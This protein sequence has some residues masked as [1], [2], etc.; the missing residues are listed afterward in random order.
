MKKLITLL[1]IV[2]AGLMF[3]GVRYTPEQDTQQCVQLGAARDEFSDLTD[4][5]VTRDPALTETEAETFMQ[6]YNRNVAN[7]LKF[8]E[9]IKK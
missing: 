1:A 5:V 2:A 8:N 7:V 6:L 9:F 4:R 3:L